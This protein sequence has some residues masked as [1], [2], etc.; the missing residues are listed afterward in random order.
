V[1]RVGCRAAP[2]DESA[3]GR[4]HIRAKTEELI[5]K[6]NATF[7]RTQA[8]Q[9]ALVET[10]SLIE[11]IKRNGSQATTAAS[12][13]NAIQQAGNGNGNHRLIATPLA[14]LSER[15]RAYYN[16]VSSSSIGVKLESHASSS[17]SGT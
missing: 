15:S 10:M 13:P 12:T 5:A 4:V 8:L 14:P 9:D 11:R 17:S 3:P 6:A 7:Q 1:R 2:S 16:S